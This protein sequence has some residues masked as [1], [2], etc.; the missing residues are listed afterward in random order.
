MN[1]SESVEL[2]ESYQNL[3]RALNLPTPSLSELA[4][5]VDNETTITLV[6]WSDYSYHEFGSDYDRANVKAM[7]DIDGIHTE[8]DA[9][10]GKAWITLGD[11]M[12]MDSI[13]E[14]ISSVDYIVELMEGLNYYPL[15]DESTHFDMVMEAATDA[16]EEYLADD[17]RNDITRTNGLNYQ[18]A[19]LV[20]D[21]YERNLEEF[22]RHYYSFEYN[23]WI[24]E[25]PTTIVNDNHSKAVSY[26][27]ARTIG[28]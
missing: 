28:K 7:A 10:A 16:W 1:F 6:E 2:L 13:R 8:D 12:G 18:M 27:L 23:W 22:H 25:S 26:A 17:I 14:V 20:S 5:A 4:D 21:W 3:F 9:G 19:D 11:D 15:L 24:F